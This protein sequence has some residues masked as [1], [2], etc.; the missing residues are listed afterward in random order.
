MITKFSAATSTNYGNKR[1]FM[2]QTQNQ[3][4]YGVNNTKPPITE[5]VTE[6]DMQFLHNYNTRMFL[7]IN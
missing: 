1:P 6:N 2:I 4:K 7:Y 3:N 5:N